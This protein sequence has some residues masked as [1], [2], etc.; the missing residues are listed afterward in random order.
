MILIFSKDRPMQLDACIVSAK[1]YFPWF[2]IAVIYQSS[3]E[4]YAHGYQMVS[5][6]HPDVSMYKEKNLKLQTTEL[7]GTHHRITFLMDD[8]LFYRLAPIPRFGS[9]ETYSLRLGDN[10]NN[11]NH[12][13]YSISLDGNTFNSPEILPLIEE[14]EFNNPNDLEARLVPYHSKF[15]MHVTEQY[16]VGLPHNRVSESSGCKYTNDFPVEYLG[17]MFLEGSRI[18]I[19]KMKFDSITGP[20]AYHI[21]YEFRHMA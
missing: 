6:Y 8:C 20:H 3:H 14:I 2:T 13:S 1:R 11:K 4:L 18:D 9:W 5:R 12:F 19:D 7:V 21:R 16:L 10:T 15:K 17:K